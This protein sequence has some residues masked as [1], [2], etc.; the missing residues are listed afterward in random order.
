MYTFIF[1]LL[2][3][4][5]SAIIIDLILSEKSDPWKILIKVIFIILI[6]VAC[7]VIIMAEDKYNSLVNDTSMEIQMKVDSIKYNDSLF[8]EFNNQRFQ[9]L[10]QECWLTWELLHS[11]YKQD[12]IGWYKNIRTLPEYKELDSFRL[13]DWED[14]Y[15]Y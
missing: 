2:V 3:L 4:L 5:G 13:G 8:I 10:A 9:N 1:L 15:L 7:N 14:F 11:I 12:S 6:I